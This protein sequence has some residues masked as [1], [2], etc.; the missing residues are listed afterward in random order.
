MWKP[1]VLFYSILKCAKNPTKIRN[2]PQTFPVTLLLIRRKLTI[3]QKAYLFFEKNSFKN[4]NTRKRCE[5]CSKL[6]IKTT[7]LKQS[8]NHLAIQIHHFMLGL[9][10]FIFGSKGFFLLFKN[11]NMESKV[12]ASLLFLTVSCFEVVKKCYKQSK[13]NNKFEKKFNKILLTSAK[14]S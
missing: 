8:K 1:F 14:K 13:L 2:R 12:Y 6:T 5:I 10:F 7:Y 3:D 9:Y 4:R 11:L